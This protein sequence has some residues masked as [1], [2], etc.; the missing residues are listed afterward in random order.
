M[1]TDSWYFRL[2][3]PAFKETDKSILYSFKEAVTHIASKRQLASTKITSSHKMQSQTNRHDSCYVT[4]RVFV[5]RATT[6]N[7]ALHNTIADLY[8]P[9]RSNRYSQE[10][11]SNRDRSQTR[12]WQVSTTKRDVSTH[13]RWNSCKLFSY[14]SRSGSNPFFRS[15]S[16]TEKI[17]AIFNQC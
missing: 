8:W 17:Q 13:L 4:S 16:S 5:S 9:D 3:N 6:T 2:L 15:F 10:S 14:S 12:V 1:Y 11:Q 7:T